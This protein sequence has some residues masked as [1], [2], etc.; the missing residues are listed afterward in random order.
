MCVY[1]SLPPCTSLP[2]FVSL[3]FFLFLSKCSLPPC[4][5]RFLSLYVFSISLCLPVCF[6]VSLY[7][8]L[9]SLVCLSFSLCISFLYLSLSVCFSVSLYMFLFSL[10]CLSLSLSLS[11]SL[12]LLSSPLYVCFSIYLFVSFHLNCCLSHVCVCFL[13][14]NKVWRQG[15]GPKHYCYCLEGEYLG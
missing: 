7:K 1:V 13:M 2:L 9:F 4:M 11:F 10:V 15:G 5:S 12:S 6:S 3:L 8:L 14:W